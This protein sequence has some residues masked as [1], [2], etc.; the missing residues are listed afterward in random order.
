ML[1]RHR[2]LAMTDKP[3]KR[4]RFDGRES[5]PPFEPGNELALVHG[6]RSERRL[7]AVADEHRPELVAVAPWL[8]DAAFGDALARYL[9][10]DARARLL[11][12]HIV[13]LVAKV[14]VGKVPSFLWRDVAAADRLAAQL[15]TRLGLDPTGKAG[16]MRDASMARHFS[17]DLALYWAEMDDDATLAGSEAETG[18][19]GALEPSNEQPPPTTEGKD[20]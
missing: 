8:D 3:P 1:P 10:A 2:L 20:Q 6:A 12:D 13:G 15:A 19:Q 17:P 11:H 5:R 14:G 18:V 7:N 4:Q 9:R 16:I